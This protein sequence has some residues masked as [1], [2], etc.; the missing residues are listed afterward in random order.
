MSK[1]KINPRRRP[2]TEADI[3]RFKNQAVSEAVELVW[4]IFFT[5]LRDKEHA[6]IDDLKRVWKECEELSDSITKGYVN[7]SDLRNVLR[8]EVGVVMR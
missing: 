2:L 7:V 1:K 4:S 5:V 8:Q 3:N 6:E